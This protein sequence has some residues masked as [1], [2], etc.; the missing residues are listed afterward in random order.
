VPEKRKDH[1]AARA[2]QCRDPDPVERVCH[3]E[4]SSNI[5]IDRF[6]LEQDRRQ[7]FCKFPWNLIFFR[8][9]FAVLPLGAARP[10]HSPEKE[11]AHI[12]SDTLHYAPE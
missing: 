11:P 2:A 12:A 1:A 8:I 6:E 3:A 5:A 9:C 7:A 10:S 4:R